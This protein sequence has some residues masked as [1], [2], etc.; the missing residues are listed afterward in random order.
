MVQIIEEDSTENIFRTLDVRPSREGHMAYSQPEW[1][2]EEI[3]PQFYD[4]EYFECGTKSGYKGYSYDGRWVPVA[5]RIIGL[6]LPSSVLDFGCAKGFLVYDLLQREVDA[7][8]ADVSEYAY[9]CAHELVKPRFMLLKDDKLDY[10]DQSLDLLVS[11][12]TLEHIS[13]K[14]L[15]QVIPELMRVSKRQFIAVTGGNSSEEKEAALSWDSSHVTIESVDWWVNLLARLGY[16]GALV[17]NTPN[18]RGLEHAASFASDNLVY[19]GNI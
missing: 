13:K 6:Y 11:R 2:D 7:Y 1:N 17:F 18:V 5:E 12:G 8:G 3:H 14:R 10:P 15:E 19:E 9:R 4:E 16:Q